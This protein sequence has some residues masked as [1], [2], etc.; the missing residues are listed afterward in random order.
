MKRISFF[1]LIL[2]YRKNKALRS[3]KR[4]RR[5]GRKKNISKESR[6]SKGG[7]WKGKKIKNKYIFEM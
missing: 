5:G 4:R 6:G 2:F 1:L 7:E 3:R